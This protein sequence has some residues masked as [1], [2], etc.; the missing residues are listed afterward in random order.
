MSKALFILAALL[1]S[2]CGHVNNSKPTWDRASWDTPGT[3]WK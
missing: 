1:I 3:A 2:S